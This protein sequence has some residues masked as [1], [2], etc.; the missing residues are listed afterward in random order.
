MRAVIFL[1]VATFIVW[2]GNKG[3]ADSTSKLTALEGSEISYNEY[4]VD[5]INIISVLNS[6]V[7]CET[8]FDIDFK[9]TWNNVISLG[10]LYAIPEKRIRGFWYATAQDD[11]NRISDRTRICRMAFLNYKKFQSEFPGL[12]VHR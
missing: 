1:A 6:D 3:I 4:E 5:I 8:K 7:F 11:M 10:V 12:F 9:A 2:L